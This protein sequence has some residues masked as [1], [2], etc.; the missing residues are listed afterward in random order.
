MATAVYDYERLSTKQGFNSSLS[1][2]K[3]VSALLDDFENKYNIADILNANLSEGEIEP[4]QLHSIIYALLVDKYGYSYRSINLPVSIEN[5]SPICDEVKKWKG[6]D[7]VISYFHPELG[8]TLINPKNPK[9]WDSV[10]LIKRDE[11]LVIFAGGFSKEIDSKNCQKAIDLMMDLLSGK[12][13]KAPA[14]L[15]NGSFSVKKIEP[16]AE[17]PAPKRRTV[18]NSVKKKG[19]KPAEKK[20]EAAASKVENHPEPAP[21]P[22]STGKKQ[23]TPMYSVNVTNE[24]FHNGNVEAWKKIIESYCAKNPG[25]EVYIFYEGERIHDINT[26]FKWGKVK[27]GSSILFAVAGEQIRDVAKLQRYLRQGASPRFEDFLRFPVN[28]VLNLF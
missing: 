25:L 9:S 4:N 7:I 26:L 10:N 5:Y 14:A 28:T 1:H 18:R 16:P 21:Q 23:M 24:L 22:Q 27:H 6:I 15:I 12:K 19:R 3:A 20:Q 2:F 11:L 8:L 13:V 17:K